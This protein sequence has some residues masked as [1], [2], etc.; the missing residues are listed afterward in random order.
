[1]HFFSFF[2]YLGITLVLFVCVPFSAQA[3]T[4]TLT[5]GMSGADVRQLQA[6][7]TAKGYLSTTATGYFGPATLAAVKKFQ[8]DKVL[9]CSGSS[10]GVVGPKTKAALLSNSTTAPSASAPVA[11]PGFEVGGWIPYWR[12]ATGTADVLPNLSKLTEVSPFVL[13]LKTD[14]T[15]F[16]AGGLNQ[17]PWVS[18][19]AAAHAQKVRVVPTV[20]SGSGDAI[21]VLLS[22]AKKRAA[23]ED[24]IVTFVKDNN[25]D[26]I[27]IDFEGK[28][29]E[30]STY[31]AAFLKELYKKMGKKWV[32]CTIEARTPISSRYT[33]VPPADAGVYANDFVAINKYCDRVQIMAYDQGTIDLLLNKSRAAPYIPV[34]DPS[35]VEKVLELTAQTIDKKKLIL[36]IATYGYEYSVTPLTEYGY[37]YDR[38]W[39]FNPG[40]ATQLAAQLGIAPVRNAAGELS[41][42]YKSTTAT[43]KAVALASKLGSV[44]INGMSNNVAPASAVYSQQAIAGSMQPP[45]NILWWSDAQAIADK[46]A[47]AK[48]MGIRGVALFKLDGGQ[49]PLMWS[50]LPNVR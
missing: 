30:T 18:F 44:A 13:T 9:V 10:F 26:G 42:I 20:M 27:D 21:H 3:A 6:A 22:D 50:V 7:L 41:F 15:L 28:K 32:Y 16:D 11:T 49:D 46:I 14:G 47:L 4:R 8:C 33:S 31:F 19:I 2:K 43:D 34:S 1:M 29:A 12:S 35:W 17:E 24:E 38:E 5:S 40:Y 48:K 39:A 36:G 45:F 37:R 25:F 23:L